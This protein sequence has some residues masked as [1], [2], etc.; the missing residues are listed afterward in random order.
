MNYHVIYVLLHLCFVYR[1]SCNRSN[2]TEY[3][4]ISPG[5]VVKLSCQHESYNDDPSF[6]EYKLFHPCPYEKNVEIAACDMG[7]WQQ[8]L[9]NKIVSLTAD[10]DRA[11]FSIQIKKQGNYTFVCHVLDHN[12]R[13]IFIKRMFIHAGFSNESLVTSSPVCDEILSAMIPS[14]EVTQ[15]TSESDIGEN[16]T[17]PFMGLNNNDSPQN[18]PVAKVLTIGLSVVIVILISMMTTYACKTRFNTCTGGRRALKSENEELPV[19]LTISVSEKSSTP[20]YVSERTTSKLLS[21]SPIESQYAEVEPHLSKSTGMSVSPASVQ[22][23]CQA[24]QASFGSTLPPSVPSSLDHL[25][26]LSSPEA[27]AQCVKPIQLYNS[28]VKPYSWSNQPLEQKFVTGASNTLPASSSYSLLPSKRP[29]QSSGAYA[30]VTLITSPRSTRDHLK[31]FHSV[32]ERHISTIP[33]YAESLDVVENS[34][35]HLRDCKFAID[36]DQKYSLDSDKHSIQNACNIL[37]NSTK[38]ISTGGTAD[39]T[40]NGHVYAVLDESDSLESGRNNDRVYAVLEDGNSQ[41]HLSEN[42]TKGDFDS[43]PPLYYELHP[44]GESGEEIGDEMAQGTEQ[45]QQDVS[46]YQPC[47]LRRSVA[48][49]VYETPS[50]LGGEKKNV[51]DKT[52]F[53]VNPLYFLEKQ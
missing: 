23:S 31:R 27:P 7:M 26:P 44:E 10:C 28:L 53:V 8:I 40:S 46:V 2:D 42:P 12:E 52:N 30:E 48:G 17:S 47:H 13:L 19:A 21:P 25:S 33:P 18:F 11:E 35:H 43:T 34:D 3:K 16:I 38:Y 4:D 45:S 14:M 36:E 50:H 22:S 6:M 1:V 20:S 49:H 29:L 51:E 39:N 41:T 37:D 32:K 24:E 15:L 5:E 9:L